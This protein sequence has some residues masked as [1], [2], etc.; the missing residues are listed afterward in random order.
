MQSYRLSKGGS[1]EIPT[2]RLEMLLK[3]V[4]LLREIVGQRVG[5]LSGITHVDDVPGDELRQIIRVDSSSV[6]RTRVKFGS[7]P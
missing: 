3:I 1:P 6:K 7:L 4:S 5:H 2:R